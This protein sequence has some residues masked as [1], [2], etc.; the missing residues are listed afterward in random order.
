MGN[1][2][3]SETNTAIT[4]PAISADMGLIS[5]PV[6]PDGQITESLSRGF[7]VLRCFEDSDMRLSNLELSQRTGLPKPTVSRLTYTLMVLGCLSYNE[8]DGTYTLGAGLLTLARPLLSRS[9]IISI[10][11]PAMEQLAKETKC[12]VAIGQPAGLSIVYINVIRGA[13]RVNL[14]VGVGYTVPILYSAMGRAYM[15]SLNPSEGTA[16]ATELIRQYDVSAT[17][18]KKTVKDSTKMFSDLGYCR[19]LGEL[20]PDVNAAAV[21]L[22]IP[23]RDEVLLLMCGGPGFLLTAEEIGKSIGPQL[24]KIAKEFKSDDI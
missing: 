19:T 4:K 23:G 10:V 5:K 17:E 3:T 9:G 22:F 7:E 11:K 14:D 16:L 20:H 18:A 6:G 12:T 13:N 8:T 2:R 21:P 15:A 1:R 24:A